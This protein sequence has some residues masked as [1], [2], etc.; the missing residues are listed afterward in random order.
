MKNDNGQR[1][2]TPYKTLPA[3][4]KDRATLTLT[5]NIQADKVTTSFSWTLKRHARRPLRV[6]FFPTAQKF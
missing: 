3:T 2:K 5:T 6:Y 4:L 1:R